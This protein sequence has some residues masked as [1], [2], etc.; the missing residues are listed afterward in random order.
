MSESCHQAFSTS[1]RQWLTAPIIQR[2][3]RSPLNT[4]RLSVTSCDRGRH[5]VGLRYAWRHTP[6][7]TLHCAVYT[8]STPRLPLSSFIR[9]GLVPDSQWH[10][11]PLQP[12]QLVLYH[13]DDDDNDDDDDAMTL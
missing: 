2:P 11:L 12:L 7:D 9:L 4:L 10:S 6:C 1:V 5:V 8:S 3:S 13:H